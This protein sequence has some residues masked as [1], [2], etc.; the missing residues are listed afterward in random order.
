MRNASCGVDSAELDGIN[1]AP[2]ALESSSCPST[3]PAK[4]LWFVRHGEGEHN[5]LCN[6]AS[7]ADDPAAA[8]EKGES[9]RDPGL[10]PLGIEQARAA[11]TDPVISRALSAPGSP[12]RAELVVASALRRTLQTALEMCSA[13]AERY[14]NP[15]DGRFRVVA[16]AEI[17]ECNA[18]PC[19]TG[20]PM[21]EL[22]E[23][24]PDVDFSELA[25]SPDDWF[26]KPQLMDCREK[27][28]YMKGLQA[29]QARCYKFIEWILNQPQERIVV[30][31]HHTL[32]CHLL[33]IEFQNCEVVELELTKSNTLSE[34]WV[35]KVINSTGPIVPAYDRKKQPVSWA[36]S[37]PLSATIGTILKTKGMAAA[38]MSA[39]RAG[40]PDPALVA[41]SQLPTP[42]DPQC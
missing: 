7:T 5:V 11:S 3:V 2:D 26:I 12:E 18:V 42:I 14:P 30:V 15:E 9:L 8:W 1:A 34:P 33:G 6:L 4:K 13:A 38:Q 36:G 31:G 19:D 25:G 37:A 20:R 32:F 27:V 23:E 39:R 21:D 41:P 28:V 22:V 29:L 10:T 24:F 16:L 40:L 17:Q 35:W